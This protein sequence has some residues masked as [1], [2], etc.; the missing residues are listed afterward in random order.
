MIDEIRV[1]IS[2]ST[3]SLAIVDPDGR[4]QPSPIGIDDIEGVRHVSWDELVQFL[5]WEEQTTPEETLDLYLQEAQ[6][7]FDRIETGRAAANIERAEALLQRIDDPSLTASV[8]SLGAEIRGLQHL[9]RA[10]EQLEGGKYVDAY[11]EYMLSMEVLPTSGGLLEQRL[12]LMRRQLEP[13]LGTVTE[14]FW[15]QGNGALQ[16]K[17]WRTA[18]GLFRQVA[19][20]RRDQSKVPNAHA[21]ECLAERYETLAVPVGRSSSD[22]ASL[23]DHIGRYVEALGHPALM[24]TRGAMRFAANWI[25]EAERA[26][27]DQVELYVPWRDATC[28]VLD[29]LGEDQLREYGFLQKDAK[30]VADMLRRCGE[31]RRALRLLWATGGDVPPAL[32]HLVGLLDEAGTAATAAPRKGLYPQEATLLLRSLES[33]VRDLENNSG[34]RKETPEGSLVGDGNQA[35]A[36]VTAEHGGE[37]S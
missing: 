5:D 28:K 18:A 32:E 16:A 26:I 12:S 9:E 11:G 24:R 27:G 33:R 3:D 10:A 4:E 13:H 21:W 1:A 37:P 19:A 17:D 34:S 7:S 23:V 15:E 8:R 6:E 30:D 35:G 14:H 20:M 29:W 36:L 22:V 25:V 2:R 31:P